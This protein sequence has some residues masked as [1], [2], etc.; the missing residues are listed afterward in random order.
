[1]EHHVLAIPPGE[2]KKEFFGAYSLIRWQFAEKHRQYLIDCGC[3]EVEIRDVEPE[4]KE[5]A[6]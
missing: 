1:M 3:T 5:D 4:A 2:T 6:K